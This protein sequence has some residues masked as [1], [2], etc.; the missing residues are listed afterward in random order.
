[1]GRLG[2]PVFLENPF[3]VV[4]FYTTVLAATDGTVS[5][6]DDIYGHD[7]ALAG[8]LAAGYPYPP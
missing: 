8:A 4:I 7:E 3:P 5:F 6:Y 2:R 1:M